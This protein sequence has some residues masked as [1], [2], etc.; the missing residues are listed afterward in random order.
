MKTLKTFLVLATMLL[1]FDAFSKPLPNGFRL[2][3]SDSSEFEIYHKVRKKAIE[4]IYQAIRDPKTILTEEA[5]AYGQKVI[6][7]LNL[8][9]FAISLNE[10]SEKLCEESAFFVKPSHPNIMFI[11]GGARNALRDESIKDFMMSVQLFMHE[12]AHFVEHRKNNYANIKGDECMPTYF[13]LVVM[14]NNLGKQQIPTMANRD[15]YKSQCG[16]AYYDDVP[17]DDVRYSSKA[18]AQSRKRNASSGGSR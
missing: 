6:S 1:T 4:M 15:G 7:E 2:L 14:E 12:A 16:F 13:E 5:I 8:T 17:S 18:I 3:E 10:E 11:C 9:K